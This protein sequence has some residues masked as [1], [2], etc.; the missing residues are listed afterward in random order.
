[1]AGFD[2]ITKQAQQFWASR[3]KRQKT[4]LAAGAAAS[5][6]VVSLFAGLLGSPEYKP[7]YSGLE[8]ADVQTLSAQLDAQSI[9]HQTSGDGKTISVPADKLDVA[10]MQT[11]SQGT[12]HS[13]RM[14]FELFDKMS[15]GQTEFDEKVT[16]QR[17][18]EG[19]LEKTIGTLSDVKTARVHLVMP[20]DSIYDDQ[21]RAAK[22]SVIVK[23]NRDSIA[24]DAVQAIARLVSGAVDGL[25][26]EDVAI[27]DA[28]S[29]RSLN[30]SHDGPM[31]GEGL[32]TSLTQRLMSTLEPIVGAGN[33]RASVNVDYDQGSSEESQ[34]KYDPAVSALLSDQKSQDQAGGGASTGG[35]PGVAS[36]VPSPKRAQSAAMNTSQG[37]TQLSTTENARYGVNRV[38]LHRVVPAGQL[39]RISAAILVDDA[40]VKN[41]AG[42]KVTFSRHARS[43]ATLNQIQQLAEAV[44]GF[45]AKRGDTISV[46]DMSFATDEDGAVPAPGIAE[47]VQKAVSDYTSLLRPMSLLVLFAMAYLFVLRPIQRQALGAGVAP[48]AEQRALASPAVAEQLALEAKETPEATRRAGQLKEQAIEQIKQ[49]PADTA[50]ALQAWLREEPL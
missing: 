24:K 27:I 36:N 50:R 48:E 38:V 42:G 35:V 14:G 33:I 39:Q 44:I 2:D 32:E 28:D 20:T 25:K 10:R 11:A 46:Q 40:V 29:D 17:A 23:L 47:R 21:Q 4:L 30:V 6:L 45:D 12:P 34:E 22:A 41:V 3:S 5:V 43:A 18:L 31:S 16:Y 9:P 19:E 37:A 1:M 7:L 49:K 15:W 8:A 13:G 26:P